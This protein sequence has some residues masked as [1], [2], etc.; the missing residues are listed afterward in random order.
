MTMTRRD[1]A[2]CAGIVTS[3]ASLPACLFSD[4]YK[5]ISDYVP[6]ALLAFDRIVMILV[7]HGINVS[8]LTEVINRVK[9]A[10]ADIQT[11]VL[12]YHDAH[13]NDKQTFIH[14]VAVALKIATER[15]V[16]FWN[17]LRIPNQQLAY[18]VKLLLDIII[19]TLTG[20]IQKL[21]PGTPVAM[22][23]FMSDPKPRTLKEFRRDFNTALA[24]QG[25]SKFA[26]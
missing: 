15:L 16:E 11:A 25:E 8:G 10:F 1:F 17:D 18:A 7:E 20:F 22:Q 14:M 23:R 4:I 12:E 9:A 2:I 6:V 24:E 13:E 26:I 21:A 19:S 3:L 5:N